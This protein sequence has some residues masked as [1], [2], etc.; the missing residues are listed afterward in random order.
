MLNSLY[1]TEMLY[2]VQ[3][4]INP[5]SLYSVRLAKITFD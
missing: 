2:I 1:S 3:Y 5:Q 4:Y